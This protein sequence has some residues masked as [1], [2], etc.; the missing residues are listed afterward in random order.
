MEPRRSLVGSN[1]RKVTLPYML[2]VSRAKC[3]L[4]R[5]TVAVSKLSPDLKR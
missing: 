5:L 3:A 1:Q 4:N 2:G